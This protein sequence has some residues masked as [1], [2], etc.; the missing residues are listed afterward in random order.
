M[1]S[2]SMVAW[3]GMCWMVRAWPGA[4][5]WCLACL[6]VYWYCGAVWYR[7]PGSHSPL[8]LSILY[9]L[10]P[11]PCGA[12]GFAGGSGRR[13]RPCRVP[14]AGR[15]CHRVVCPAALRRVLVALARPFGA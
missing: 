15:N 5:V 9:A 13:G 6:G 2:E 7:V 8:S 1:V 14:V 3:S 12:G 4:A 11:F 10:S